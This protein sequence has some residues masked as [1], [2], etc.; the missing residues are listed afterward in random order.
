[1]RTSLRGFGLLACFVCVVVCVG[2]ERVP[3][4]KHVI[5]AEMRRATENITGARPSPKTHSTEQANATEIS[6]KYQQLPLSFEPNVGQSK[7]PANYIAH[8]KGYEVQLEPAQVSLR[9][10]AGMQRAASSMAM[11][12]VDANSTSGFAALDRLP[13]KSNY[14]IGTRPEEWRTNISTFGKVLEKAVYPGIDVAYY[15]TQRQL[16]Y[17]FVVAPGADANLIRFRM[18][19]ADSV[20]I[21]E[22][23]DLLVA[24]AGSEL[25]F[26]KPLAY[27][28]KASAK[29][30][31]EVAYAVDSTET[32]S[33]KIGKHDPK[34]ALVIDPILSYSTYLDGSNIDGANAIALAPNGTAFIA[35]GT[36]STDFPTAHPLQPNHGGPDDLDR[37]VFVAKLSADG[38]T[39][40]YSTYLGG[41]NDDVGTGIAVDTFG[42]AY[43]TGTTRSPDYP[44]TQGSLNVECGGDGKC[45][46]SWNPQGLIVS[47]GFVTKLNAAGSGLIYSTFIG[48]Y[49]NVRCQAIAVDNNEVAYITGPT[50]ADIMPT[51]PIIPPAT[52]PPPFLRPGLGSF[53]AVFGGGQSDAFVMKISAT[54]STDLYLSYLGGSNEDIGYG[55]AVDG[56]AN[57]Y[58]TGLTYSTDFPTANPLQAANGGAGDAFV[59]KVNTQGSGAASLVFSTFL[60]GNGL[61]QGNGVAVD[62]GGNLYVAGGSSSTSLVGTAGVLQ[63][64]CH[65][66]AA[67]TCEGDAF[68][69]KFN[70]GAIPTLAYLTFLGGSF[71]DT[72]TGIAVEP[73]NPPSGFA[74][75]TGSTVSTDFP[76]TDAVFQP[77]FGGGNADAFVAKLDPAGATLLYSSYLGGTNTDIGYGIAADTGG[78]AYV[79]GQTCSLDFPLANPEQVTPGGNCDAFVSKV[80][81]LN[82]IQVN[83]AGLVFSAQSLM[84]TS[85][86]QTVTVTNGDI[87]VT[88]SAIAVDPSSPNGGDFIATTTCTTSLGVGGKCTITVV[89]AP[90]GPGLRKASI[91][92]LATAPGFSQNVVVSLNGQASTLT[93]SAASLTFGQQQVG[94]ASSAPMSVTATNNGTTPV[95]FSSIT[96]SGDFSETDN[97]T[98]API[99][100]STNCV[101]NVTYT[102]T[103]AGTS[104]GALTISDNAPGSPQI[105]LLTGTGVGQQSDFTLTAVSSSAS[106]PAGQPATFSLTL[107]SFGG[108]NQ[109]VSLSCSGLP[110]RASCLASAN[111]VTPGS[112]G[113]AVNLTVTTATRNFLPPM[114]HVRFKPDLRTRSLSSIT[115][116]LLVLMVLLLAMRW[117]VPARRATALVVIAFA[118]VC[119]I[120]GCN[121]GGSAGV[122][123]G[124]PAGVYQITVTGTSGSLSHATSLTLQVK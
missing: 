68:V 6:R 43:V 116:A 119:V 70:S 101:I 13:G 32:V 107:N 3:V 89:F 39:L 22:A 66:D 71:A 118:T 11:Q 52:P 7:T 120:A 42:D 103:T 61:D 64:N 75:V 63:V 94:V 24:L 104:V 80:S 67:N 84:T 117:G 25:R 98:K 27:Q 29:R 88:L 12:F 76:V 65:L 79:A 91:S 28:E 69:A 123:A 59:T 78:N 5:S 81:T 4:G 108:F 47:N 9:F 21:D 46:A 44:V 14:L 60:G 33:F 20:R 48:Y 111:P 17:D 105:V 74:Y 99:Q 115:V 23:G 49:E 82:G 90:L 15:G 97:C 92:I 86:P 55:I 16:E 26:H 85:Q 106:V 100:P 122:P 73:V 114:W 1:M 95:T 31:V 40:L 18:R 72:A 109:P 93:L 19:G 36:F 34:L 62:R 10:H 96:A 121:S 58:I 30:A 110:A 124:T 8:G 56:S 102:P 37:D 57:A 112:S 54:G 113:T 87:P 38:S 50:S 45:G 35:G 83:P 41:K 77:K 53:Q 2:R 51:V